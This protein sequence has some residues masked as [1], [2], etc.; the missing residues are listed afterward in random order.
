[1]SSQQQPV[2][3]GTPN[4]ARALAV[5]R[6]REILSV[7]FDKI[8]MPPP[9][10][11]NN[12]RRKPSYMTDKEFY[13]SLDIP[14]LAEAIY[15][16]NG[17]ADPIEG[18]SV[19]GEDIFHINEGQRRYLAI[20]WLLTDGRDL[21][22]NGRPIN[23][24]EVLP[25]PKGT[26]ARDRAKKNY[27][28]QNKQKLLPSQIADG[29]YDYQIQVEADEGIKLTH[30]DIAADFGVSRQ[31]VDNMFKIRTLDD[32]TKRKLDAGEITQ[33]EAL[34]TVRKKKEPRPVSENLILVDK[35]TGAL[36]ERTLTSAPKNENTPDSWTEIIP[37][38]ICAHLGW[39]TE[40]PE[41]GEDVKRIPTSDHWGPSTIEY[42]THEDMDVDNLIKIYAPKKE[43]PPISLGGSAALDAE[44]ASRETAR[45]LPEQ[46]NTERKEAEE[47]MKGLDYR[48]DKERGEFEINECIKLLDKLDTQ[49]SHLPAHQ[50]QA[51]KDMQGLIGF[52][53][54]KMNAVLEI[55]K[56]APDK[57]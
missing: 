54:S 39:V 2:Q 52:I 13:D 27:T 32:D 26:T 9:G 20:G 24:V 49:V 51:K 38:H 23:I 12:W 47:A 48:P 21:Y 29:Y 34:A 18:D 14:V 28:S 36:V 6:G 11:G 42:L 46:Q 8:T 19:V 50:D 16:N 45:K 53:Q 37:F 25:N 31:Y 15:N 41:T 30:E 43:I 33:T 3:Y 57:S 17:P 40:D 55:I 44:F 56:K 4:H 1:M 7:P 10:P 5:K 35:E 22:P